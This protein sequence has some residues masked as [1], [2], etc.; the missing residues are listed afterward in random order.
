MQEEPEEETHVVRRV[1]LLAPKHVRIVPFRAGQVCSF[2]H[3]DH[4]LIQSCILSLLSNGDLY[5]VAQV[6]W[7]LHDDAIAVLQ[8]RALKRFGIADSLLHAL[9]RETDKGGDLWSDDG[10]EREERE[11]Y[12]A[13]SHGPVEDLLRG[14]RVDVSEAGQDGLLPHGRA[15][16]KTARGGDGRASRGGGGMSRALW[17]SGA[18][19]GVSRAAGASQR[20]GAASGARATAAAGGGH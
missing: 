13:F 9:R 1:T 3:L 15:A 6:A 2:V 18:D 7:V 12:A 11:S 14:C 4:R 19:A 5:N 8:E 17:M 20:G 10:W 16:E